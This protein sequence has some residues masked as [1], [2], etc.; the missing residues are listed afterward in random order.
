MQTD[1]GNTRY[2]TFGM[3][4][5]WRNKSIGHFAT[6]DALGF[7]EV[8]LLWIMLFIPVFGTRLIR[9]EESHRLGIDHHSH[10]CQM[11]TWK[12]LSMPWLSPLG[13]YH[14][15]ATRTQAWYIRV[16]LIKSAFKGDR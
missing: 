13:H 3:R 4:E 1:I 12:A 9:H 14:P 16:Q 11:N 15:H 5:A 10:W 2:R 7:R 8:G 6:S